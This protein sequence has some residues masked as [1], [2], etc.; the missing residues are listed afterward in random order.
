MCQRLDN[1][2]LPQQVLSGGGAQ[3]LQAS[4]D[5]LRWK[6]L[7]SST[8]TS[9][10]CCI[11]LLLLK[12]YF[13]S[14]QLGKTGKPAPTSFLT[15]S[16][17]GESSAE[18]TGKAPPPPF[19]TASPL[20]LVVH[21][22][23]LPPRR[24]HLRKRPAAPDR[25]NKPR[26]GGWTRQEALCWL[27]R[28]PAWDLG[29][30]TCAAGPRHPRSRPGAGYTSGNPFPPAKQEEAEVQLGPNNKQTKMPV[31]TDCSSEAA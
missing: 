27:R 11:G 3:A 2:P 7:G 20:P 28:R 15:G 23:R 8:K 4:A 31:G 6:Q 30:G 13:P 14:L 9:I 18:P 10:N 21:D 16:G 24:R 22:A 29:P 26:G 19:Q 5:R 17:E 1:I 12:I 25:F